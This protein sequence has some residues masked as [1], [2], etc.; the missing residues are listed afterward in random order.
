MQTLTL[1]TQILF[2][3]CLNSCTPTPLVE[4]KTLIATQ[5]DTIVLPDLYAD[6]I[7]VPYNVEMGHYFKFM[8]SLVKF[9]TPQ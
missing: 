2:I 1:L 4:T 9:Y 7:V 8:D 5:K 3:V 6:T